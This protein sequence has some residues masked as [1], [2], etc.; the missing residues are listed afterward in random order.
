LHEHSQSRQVP[1]VTVLC[2]QYFT[3]DR[4][5]INSRVSAFLAMRSQ[6]LCTVTVGIHQS[7]PL[8]VP[9]VSPRSYFGPTRTESMY[10]FIAPTFIDKSYQYTRTTSLL[11][12]P[13]RSYKRPT[14]SHSITSTS[15]F[16][17]VVMTSG[18]LFVAFILLLDEAKVA[19][20]YTKFLWTDKRQ[21]C[22]GMTVFLTSTSAIASASLKMTSTST[23]SSPAVVT[24]Y[25]TVTTNGLSRGATGGISGGVLG[26]VALQSLGSPFSSSGDGTES[27]PTYPCHERLRAVISELMKKLD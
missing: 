3:G 13:V 15:T 18:T 9:N 19:V 21:L 4:R 20:K 1:I 26:G 10:T 27:V 14:N 6:R 22:P 7:Y 16:L 24:S 12:S 11:L 25:V 2:H 8:M 5:S 23:S 17:F